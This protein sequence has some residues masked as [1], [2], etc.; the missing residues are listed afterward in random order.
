MNLW[1]HQI[2]GLTRL[3]DAIGAGET[4]ICVTAPTGGGKSR[5]MAERILAAS[6]P[7]VVYT[8]RKMLLSQLSQTLWEHGLSFGFRAAGYD[9]AL[10]EDLQLA[11]VQTE[12]SAVLTA[13]SREIHGADEIHIDEAHNNA[14]GKT[15][16]LLDRHDGVRIGWTATPLSIGHAYDKLIVAGTNSE[17]RECGALVPAKHFGPDEPSK[18]LVGAVKI[19][20]GECGISKAKRAVYA[21]RVFGSV[22]ENY[23]RFNP[24][25]KPALLFAPGVAESIWFCE[26]LTREGVKSAHID[27]EHCWI[28]GRLVDTTEETREE[29]RDRCERGDIKIVCNRFVLREGVDWPFIQHGIFATVFGSL[30]SYLQAGGR[31]LRA[32]PSMR[33]VTVCDHGGNWWRHGSLNADREWDLSHTNEMAAGIRK[34]QLRQNQEWQPINCPK[35]NGIRMGGLKCHHCGHEVVKIARTRPVLQVNGT[36]KPMSIAELRER[37][38]LTKSERLIKQW[39]GKVWGA[40]KHKPDRTFAQVYANFARENNWRYPPR[41]LPMMP[42]Q[43]EDW[44]R[45]VGNVPLERLI[46]ENPNRTTDLFG[47]AN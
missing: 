47:R 14:T 15:L 46:D 9:K 31:L 17:L 28:D 23:H 40:R 12:V 39:S 30:T 6:V 35:C 41:D 42:K 2:E 38:Y 20:E 24:L 43:L 1:P 18:S 19:G 33:S 26:T 8:H 4:R 11:M 16:E 36:L 3:R 32:H 13:K 44:F 34:E 25:G 29:I 10:L 5:C 45:P 37:R 7:A 22:L 21:K 27:G